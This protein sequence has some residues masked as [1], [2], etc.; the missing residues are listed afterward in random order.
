LALFPSNNSLEVE[1]VQEAL[2]PV[3]ALQSSPPSKAP[4]AL[5]LFVEE[6]ARAF[7]PTLGEEEK[8]EWDLWR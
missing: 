3:Q 6:W 8:L 7:L 5:A 4:Q 2:N 1:R